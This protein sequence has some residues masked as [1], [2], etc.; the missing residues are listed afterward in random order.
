MVNHVRTLLLNRSRDNL[1]GSWSEYVD[2]NFSKKPLPAYLDSAWRVLFG[3]NPDKEM[4]NWRASQYMEMLDSTEFG[5]Y[6]TAIDSRVSYRLPSTISDVELPYVVAISANDDATP[7]V[8]VLGTPLDDPYNGRLTHSF[9]V[10]KIS[11]SL[12]IQNNFSRQVATATA[13][14]N[15]GVPLGQS[16]LSLLIEDSIGGDTSVR[17]VTPEDFSELTP[18]QLSLLETGWDGGDNFWLVESVTTPSRSLVDIMDDLKQLPVGHTEQIFGPATF[19]PFKTF[20][21]LWASDRG[22]A[23]KFSGLLLA[24]AYRQERLI[25]G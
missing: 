14:P 10:T 3:G 4:L 11:D 18:D 15:E 7:P 23:Y 24:W 21:K 12:V 25:N 6:V 22:F 13:S 9:S 1:S 8:S 5:T 20:R 16:G 2:P 17:W 19:E